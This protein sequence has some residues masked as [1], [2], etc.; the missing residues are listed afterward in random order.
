MKRI[1]KEN[2]VSFISVV[3]W[4]VL[5]ATALMIV[6][7]FTTVFLKLLVWSTKINDEYPYYLLLLPIVLLMVAIIVW[8]YNKFAK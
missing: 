5:A 1:I 3:K 6:G 7:C 2:P 4:V 8:L